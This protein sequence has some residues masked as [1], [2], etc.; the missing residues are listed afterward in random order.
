M[1][2]KSNR[3]RGQP[4]LDIA[5]RIRH[6]VWYYSVKASVLD[7]EG[8]PLSD[9][10]LDE[11]YLPEDRTGGNRQRFFQRIRSTGSSPKR[12]RA[13]LGGRSVFQLVHAKTSPALD[14]VRADDDSVLWEILTNPMLSPD[15]FNGIIDDISRREGWYRANRTDLALGL[16]FVPEDPAF[17]FSIDAV[18]VR[19][20][21]LAY[22]QNAPSADHVALLIA[23]Y[24]RA[25][26][27]SRLEWA[28]DVKRALVWCLILWR[29]DDAGSFALPEQMQGLL[30]QI[31]ERRAIEDNWEVPVITRRKRGTQRSFVRAQIDSYL[32]GK[33]YDFHEVPIVR[34]S[35]VTRWLSRNKKKL[36]LILDR[37]NRMPI[38]SR[39]AY[40]ATATSKIATPPRSQTRYCLPVRTDRRAKS[41]Q[42][43]PP[44]L[45][46]GSLEGLT[47]ARSGG[48][49]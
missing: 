29:G 13:D 14:Q 39:S 22:L 19:S 42:D 33:P 40:L 34:H 37:A 7:K 5:V 16:A 43:I 38:E 36:Q 3:T 21:M 35:P 30:F 24:K 46:D 4:P 15:D 47:R 27:R 28:I 8:N 6:W 10:A 49:P 44:Y 9:D 45:E 18:N 31:V 48:K 32:D 12:P 1:R 17:G 41:N 2:R 11:K 20:S 26:A 25:L 23:L